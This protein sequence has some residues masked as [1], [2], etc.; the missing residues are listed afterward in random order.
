MAA[1]EEVAEAES[2]E[3]EHD[4]ARTELE[5][6]LNKR[7]RIGITDGRVIDGMFLCTDRDCNIVLGNCEEFLSQDEVGEIC[8]GCSTGAS[9]SAQSMMDPLPRRCSRK[10]WALG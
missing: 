4:K 8:S 2:H 5:S 10:H 9:R 7:M 1:S 6:Y 3:D